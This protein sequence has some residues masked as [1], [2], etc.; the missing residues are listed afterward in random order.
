MLI[1]VKDDEHTAYYQ[2]A[3]HLCYKNGCRTKLTV[4]Q[5]T[6]R[7]AVEFRVSDIASAED[8]MAEIQRQAGD[9]I[10]VNLP[11]NVASGFKRVDPP[12]RLP[13][14]AERMMATIVIDIDEGTPSNAIILQANENN[15]W[16][17]EPLDTEIVDGQASAQTDGGGYF[18]VAT[19][20]QYGLVVGIPVA[21]VIILL[22]AIIVLL[23]VIYFR[24]RPEKWSSAKESVQK[25]QMKIK[26]SFAKQI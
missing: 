11:A 9:D 18:V 6:L 1:T 7:E 21:I 24:L 12:R 10:N 8:A 3:F 20:L 5:G 26:R 15:F 14:T 16:I 17:F 25:S 13:Q 23:L 4:P 19:P 2:H 22:I